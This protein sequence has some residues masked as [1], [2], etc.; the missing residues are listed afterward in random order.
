MI[1]CSNTFEKNLFS[2]LLSS[3]FGPKSV[4]CV[5]MDQFLS[6]F[7]LCWGPLFEFF[8]NKDGTLEWDSGRPMT[9]AFWSMW[10]EGWEEAINVCPYLWDHRPLICE[11]VSFRWRVSSV[12][13]LIVIILA[14]GAREQ[15]GKKK[16]K[17]KKKKTFSFSWIR[18]KSL[19]LFLRLEFSGF[20][21][22]LSLYIL[23]K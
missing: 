4:F 6:F 23:S 8:S 2:I 11:E 21:D 19:F 17:R 16:K 20:S 1:S 14:W 15:N 3:H 9:A 5:C 12:H 18:N 22:F 13:H 10:K 7:L